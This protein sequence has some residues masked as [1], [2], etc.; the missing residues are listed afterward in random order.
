MS[1]L[2]Q[3]CRKQPLPWLALAV[4][5]PFIIIVVG[6]GYTR[7]SVAL[8]FILLSRFKLLINYQVFVNNRLNIECTLCQLTSSISHSLTTNRII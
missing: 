5:A 2:V 4:A 3:F 7:Q 1:G 6:M 8:G